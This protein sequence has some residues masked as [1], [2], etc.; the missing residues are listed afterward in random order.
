MTRWLAALGALAVA[1]LGVA[2]WLGRWAAELFHE[3]D[4]FYR[5]SAV[6]RP[7]EVYRYYDTLSNNSWAMQ[8]I[9]TPLLSGAVLAVL[10]LLTVLALRWERRAART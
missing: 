4:E 2:V 6:E 9:L 3:V 7:E 1:C 8:G 10:T 5:S